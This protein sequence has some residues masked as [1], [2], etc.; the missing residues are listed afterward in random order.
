MPAPQPAPSVSQNSL[1]ALPTLQN[2]QVLVNGSSANITVDPVDNAVDYRVYVMPDKANIVLN[3]DGTLAGVKNAIYRCAGQRVAPPVAKD[4]QSTIFGV[5]AVIDGTKPLQEFLPNYQIY[6]DADGYKRKPSEATLG[7]VSSVPGTGLIPVYA[8]G[9]PNVGADN[10]YSNLDPAGHGYRAQW[11]ASRTKKYTTDASERATLIKARWRDDGIA[12]YVPSTPSSQTRQVYTSTAAGSGTSLSRFYFIDGAEHTLHAAKSS[13]A[14]LAYN[15]QVAGT[16]PL[17]RVMYYLGAGATRHDEL[18]AGKPMFDRIYGQ[19]NS[20]MFDIHWSGITGPTQLVVEALDSGCPFQ[21]AVLAPKNLAAANMVTVDGNQILQ[22]W[23]TIQQFMSDDSM[24]EVF[25]NGQYDT[26]VKPHPIARTVIKV[27]PQ[28]L[29]MEWVADFTG[30]AEVYTEPLQT[31]PMFAGQIDCGNP[32][33]VLYLNGFQN[34]GG[35]SSHQ[36]ISKNYNVFFNQIEEQMLPRYGFGPVLGQMMSAY[37]DTG[38][39]VGGKF[40][41]APL[42]KAKLTDNSFLHV[43]M[44]T[45]SVSTPRRYPQMIISDQNLPVTWSMVQ[46]N[47]PNGTPLPLTGRSVIIQQIYHWPTQLKVEICDSRPWEVND[48]CPYYDFTFV[49]TPDNPTALAN[50][51]IVAEHNGIDRSTRF[52]VYMS[53]SKLYV[54]L[55]NIPYG[56]ANLPKQ[57]PRAPTA[58]PVTVTYGDVLY[59]SSADVPFGFVH[60]HLHH[61]A[62]HHYDNLGYSSGVAAPA[63]DETVLPCVSTLIPGSDTYY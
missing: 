53:T 48:Q 46:Q 11:A 30:P 54:F 24:G 58:G 9:D 17:M 15:T 40:R 4:D 63:W 19:G 8:L 28:P 32:I 55:D 27:Q 23:K 44:E 6:P 41:I 49:G 45:N 14:F 33:S 61:E 16:K 26:A 50:V 43:T 51:P 57:S 25:V 52:D 37:T 13:A 12:F 31:S 56:C 35:T 2:V 59:H 42:Q 47:A 22:A 34:C 7:Y 21:N 36:L 39:D 10:N 62:I 20:P 1:P 60:S 29:A 18:V 38:C 5:H 3:S